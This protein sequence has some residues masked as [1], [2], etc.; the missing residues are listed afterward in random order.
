MA[1][2]GAGRSGV[3]WWEGQEGAAR[4]IA[5]VL[6]SHCGAEGRGGRTR[7][8]NGG[9]AADVARRCAED[10]GAD[11]PRHARAAGGRDGGLRA[12]HEEGRAER[13]LVDAL[14]L[15]DKAYR[16]VSPCHLIAFYIHLACS[17]P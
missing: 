12:H 3:G 15:L 17:I 5:I 9:A 11:A 16:S 6:W 4:R 8:P 1:G 10:R 14:Q 7:R 13:A 2:A